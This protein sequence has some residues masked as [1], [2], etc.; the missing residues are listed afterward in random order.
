[1]YPNKIKPL[2]IGLTVV[3]IIYLIVEL[4]FNARLLDAVGTGA[5]LRQINILEF[6]GRSLSGI[7]AALIVFQAS[8]WLCDKFKK[9]GIGIS[10]ILALIA[11]VLTYIGIE[12]FVE[13][14]VNNTDATFKKISLS[15]GLLQSALV[16]GKIQLPQLDSNTAIFTTPE[17]K[18]LVAI[19]PYMVSQVDN[20]ESIIKPIKR[21]IIQEKIE[22]SMGGAEGYY[23]QY[24]KGLDAVRASY[25][26]YAAIPGESDINSLIEREFQKAWKRYLSDLGKH[27]WTPSSVPEVYQSRVIKNVRKNVKIPSDWDLQDQQVFHDAVASKIRNKAQKNWEIKPGLS[28]NE[29]FSHA[30]IQKQIK[31]E[32][33][34][35]GTINLKSSYESAA[36]FERLVYQPFLERNVNERI[37]QYDADVINFEH[38]GKNY[39]LGLDAAKIS[40]S[41]P[42]ALFFSM[43]GAI[44]HGGKLLYLIS[45]LFWKTS[46]V[47]RFTTLLSLIAIVYFVLLANLQNNVTQSIL[48]ARLSNEYLANTSDAQASISRKLKLQALHNIVVGQGY[49]YPLNEYIRVNVLHGFTFGFGHN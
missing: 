11:T 2:D 38:N 48:Y 18:A 46:F 44:L 5:A 17:G 39:Q 35:P 43:M 32:M 26:K 24:L 15:V 14:S 16:N 42:L 25:K 27:G 31:S 9:W 36:D 29:Y 28:W 41:V 12:K 4:S 33:G 30:K 13:N 19:F 34:L 1:M 6:F 3:T 20:L 10:L 7:A 22:H 49:S 37:Q 8:M 23:E 40:I 45:K 47:K 21:K